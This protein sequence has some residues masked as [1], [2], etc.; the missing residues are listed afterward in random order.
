MKLKLICFICVLLAFLSGCAKPPLAEMESAREAVLRA[1]N[2]PVVVQYA[3]S[4]LSRA[5]AALRRMQTEAE[6]KRYD[7]VKTLAAEAIAAAD[8]AVADAKAGYDRA[9]NEAAA[10]LSGLKPEIEE[11]GKGID[12]ARAAGFSL[13]YNELNND[14]KYAK[15]S[16]EKAEV[17]L[18]M[19][20]YQ[21][22]L[23]NGKNAR[24]ALGDINQK[25]A[26]AAPRKK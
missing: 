16:A 23:D 9:R 8:K 2:D 20:R 4:S 17:D 10:L 5:Q 18:A 12:K 22:A 25:L 21:N 13:N 19:N 1:E 7:A 26:N 15:D 24:A 11:A 14:L 3:A 6:S